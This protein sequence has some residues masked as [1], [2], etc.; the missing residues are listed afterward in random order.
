[1]ST[2]FKFCSAMGGASILRN[3]SLFITSPLDLNDP[4]EMRPAWTDAHEQRHREDRE[5]RNRAMVGS[6]IFVATESGLRPMGRMHRLEE[7][8]T[9]LV[10]SHR[11]ISDTHNGEV[12]R[13]IHERFRV[14]SFATGILE[15]GPSHVESTE[16]S[17]LLWSHYADSFQGICL[18]FDPA[19]LENGIR[20]GGFLVT[21]SPSREGLPTDFYDVY[22][23][24]FDGPSTGSPPSPSDD[25]HW[26]AM[27]RFLTQKSSAWGY[28]QE[29]R[30]IYDLS[31]TSK[32]AKFDRVLIPCETCKR[33]QRLGNQ[34]ANPSYRDVIAFPPQAIQAVIFGTDVAA[35][36]ATELLRLLDMAEFA[37]VLVYWSS[38]HSDQYILQYNL[39]RREGEE[40]KRY[41]LFMQQLRE[42][43]IAMAK[44]HV[45]GAAGGLKYRPA[46]K[47]VCYAR[48]DWG[49][50]GD[51]K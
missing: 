22:R 23:R 34:C 36:E 31:D 10:D 15:I 24:W 44:G 14:L 1:M 48:T 49:D 26:Q 3:R 37:H 6:P 40:G 38:L 12:F 9:M 47:G 2:V 50:C 8:P 19:R 7:P 41:S 16:D 29:L 33:Q 13:L 46:K 17:T 5:L 18:A 39:D 27:V 21:Y 35:E 42:K 43:Q 45:S 11:G 51:G 30:M 20:D 32:S 25:R 4:F 28:E